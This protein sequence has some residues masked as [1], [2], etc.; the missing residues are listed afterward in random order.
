L[1]GRGSAS[2]YCGLPCFIQL[3][4]IPASYAREGATFSLRWPAESVDEQPIAPATRVIISDNFVLTF[5][6]FIEVAVLLDVPRRNLPEII[7]IR[8]RRRESDGAYQRT[9]ALR[10]NHP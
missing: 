9:G 6:G 8:S 10:S 2:T 1:D 4:A 3:S 7:Q 5:I